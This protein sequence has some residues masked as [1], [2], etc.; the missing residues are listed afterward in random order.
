MTWPGLKTRLCNKHGQICETFILFV[1]T[2][3]TQKDLP[4]FSR[5]G[6]KSHRCTW[7]GRMSIALLLNCA[8]LFVFSSEA[9]HHHKPVSDMIILLIKHLSEQ[10]DLLQDS[11]SVL[12]NYDKLPLIVIIK[13]FGHFL[14]FI[15]LC[16]AGQQHITT[17]QHDWRAL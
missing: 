11:I 13:Y 7:T 2:T 17:E 6:H 16:L 4:S 1:K 15:F 9:Q 12:D 8:V 5:V 10:E 3:H 14:T